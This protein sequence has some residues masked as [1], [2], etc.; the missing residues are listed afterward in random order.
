MTRSIQVAAPWSRPSDLATMDGL[1]GGAHAE[2]GE[3]GHH[4]AISSVVRKVRPSIFRLLIRSASNTL[5]PS[6]LSAEI[7]WLL[8]MAK[9]DRADSH[10]SA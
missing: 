5:D 3:H 9:R 4:Y 2:V 10:L 7:A 6:R 8:R 1:G